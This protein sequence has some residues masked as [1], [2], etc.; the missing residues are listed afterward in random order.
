MYAFIRARV[1]LVLAVLHDLLARA[2]SARVGVVMLYHR[3]DEVAGDPAREIVPA[4]SRTAFAMQVAV[5]SRSYRVVPA[6]KL[7]AAVAARRRGQRIPVAITFDDDLTGHAGVVADVL[8]EAGATATF[9]LCG[10]SLHEPHRFWWERLQDAVDRGL[11]IGPLLADAGLVGAAPVGGIN[12][13]A[14]A[15][16]LLAP[17]RRLELE[18]R[19]GKLVGPDPPDAGLRAPQVAALVDK[20]FDIG[21]HTREHSP[22]MFLDEGRLEAALVLGRAELE[23]AGRAPLDTIAYPHG[24]GDARVAA[25]AVAHGFVL[26]FTTRRGA[27]TARSDPRLLPRV[28][29]F[30]VDEARFRLELSRLVLAGRSR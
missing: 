22:L 8:A 14:R 7:P 9:F 5:L 24:L 20:G 2:S 10:A 18:R 4:L 3:I 23:E 12:A 17:E 16:T 15:V 11:A 19:L 28:E 6:S 27:V 1:L 29:T 26:G 30:A 13:I 21:F 25:H